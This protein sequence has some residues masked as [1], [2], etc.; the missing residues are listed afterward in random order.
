MNTAQLEALYEY[1]IATLA[2]E[3]QLRLLAIVAQRLASTASN[4]SRKKYNVLEFAGAGKADP[5]GMDAQEYV[6]QLRDEWEHRP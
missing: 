1:H 4:Q 3:D 6:H 5:I 2:E